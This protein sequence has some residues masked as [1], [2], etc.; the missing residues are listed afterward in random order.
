M[1]LKSFYLISIPYGSIKSQLAVS[2]VSVS[3]LFQFLMVRLKGVFHLRGDCGAW[4]FQFLMVRLK[5]L[6]LITLATFLRFQFLMVRLKGLIVLFCLER[7]SI[8]IP[9]GSIKRYRWRQQRKY[10]NI[11]IPYGSIKSYS[12]YYRLAKETPISIPY[13]SI[14]REKRWDY[15]HRYRISIPYGSIKRGN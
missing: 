7:T 11:S 15:S 2:I 13:G 4:P 12:P 1:S 3:V 8:S 9:Y 10:I 6:L 5:A 14:K